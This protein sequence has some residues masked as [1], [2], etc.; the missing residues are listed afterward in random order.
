M[1]MQTKHV[2]QELKECYH[3]EINKVKNKEERKWQE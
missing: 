3:M 2:K 1:V